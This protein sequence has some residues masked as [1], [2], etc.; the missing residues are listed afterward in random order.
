MSSKDTL[1]T[2]RLPP[3]DFEM[4]DISMRFA[5][6]SSVTHERAL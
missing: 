4:F 5:T 1:S 2:A 6:T 3:N